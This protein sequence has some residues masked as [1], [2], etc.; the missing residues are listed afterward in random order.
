MTVW[1][2]AR[3]WLAGEDPT[4]AVYNQH[5]RDQFR[6][7]GDAY[8]AYIPVWTGATTNPV[9]GNG[10]ITGFYRA[11]GKHISFRVLIL[12]GSTTTFGSGAYSIT[13]PPFIPADSSGPGNP[14]ITGFYNN[15]ANP[16]G[17]F[18]LGNTS[19]TFRMVMASTNSYMSQAVPAAHANGDEICVGGSYEAA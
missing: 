18:V 9:I 5:I 19:T 16:A 13:Y 2:T 10:S 17:F 7:L 8:L 1:S 6:V 3:T 12:A 14:G 15:G 4:A 11:V